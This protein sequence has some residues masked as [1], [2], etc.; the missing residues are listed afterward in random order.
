[1]KE[2]MVSQVIRNQNHEPYLDAFPLH[3]YCA[4]IEWITE[5]FWIGKMDKIDQRCDFSGVSQEDMDKYVTPLKKFQSDSF[6]KSMYDIA[7]DYAKIK[8]KESVRKV[9]GL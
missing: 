4:C 1:M 3:N 2:K 8:W 7:K 5:S 6:V 9:L